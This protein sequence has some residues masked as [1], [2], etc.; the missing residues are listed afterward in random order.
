MWPT[1][2]ET[3][4]LRDGRLADVIALLQVLALDPHTHRSEEGLI[5]DLTGVPKSAESWVDL[6]SEHPEFF[7][8]RRGETVRMSLVARHVIP[9]DS[10]G[11]RHLPGDFAGQLIEAAINLHDRQ[12]RRDERWTYLVPVWVALVAG[13]FMLISIYTKII[14]KLN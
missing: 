1:R 3:R 4:Y 12:I 6:A 10:T 11:V 2:K 5:K 7:R 13:I 14:L 9:E 8:V